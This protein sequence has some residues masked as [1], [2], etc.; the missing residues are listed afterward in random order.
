MK[1]LNKLTNAANRQEHGSRKYD[2]RKAPKCTD[3]RRA[4]EYIMDRDFHLQHCYIHLTDEENTIFK[5][6]CRR[7]KEQIK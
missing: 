7:I 1:G 2:G 6:Y 4:C 3:C 5:E